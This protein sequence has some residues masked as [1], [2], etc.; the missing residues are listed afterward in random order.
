[1]C[2]EETDKVVLS[3]TKQDLETAFEDQD[4]EK[5]F[6][7]DDDADDLENDKKNQ[8][9]AFLSESKSST[10]VRSTAQLVLRVN[11]RFK[12]DVNL[13]E[14][15]EKEWVEATRKHIEKTLEENRRTF[16]KKRKSARGSQEGDSVAI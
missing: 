12:E 6:Q 1:M 13:R 9:D 10:L 14:P 16:N 2:V 15:I 8:I 4:F 7:E 11:A 3:K 5:M